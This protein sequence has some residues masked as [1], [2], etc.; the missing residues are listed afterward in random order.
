MT[1]IKPSFLWLMARSNWGQKSGQEC[2]LAV[3]IPRERWEW[4]L[5]NAALTS[6]EKAVYRDGQDWESARQQNPILIQWD[7]ERNLRGDKLNHRSIQVGLGRSV[8]EEYSKQWILKLEDLRP[9][10]SKI[11]GLCRTGDWDRAARHLPEEK[12]YPLPAELARRIGATGP[13]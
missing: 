5:S 11:R 2:I 4:A 6:P 13:R 8:A 1:W 7:P 12:P 10:V 9:L 3:H